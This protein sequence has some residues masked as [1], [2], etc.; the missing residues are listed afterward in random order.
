MT[1]GQPGKVQPKATRCPE[2]YHGP[3]SER[4]EVTEVSESL[5][6]PVSVLTHD[7]AATDLFSSRP[8]YIFHCFRTRAG[9]QENMSGAERE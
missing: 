6:C 1:V 5:K 2:I 4:T 9:R 7:S 8:T 3:L